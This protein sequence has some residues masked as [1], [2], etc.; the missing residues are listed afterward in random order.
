MDSRMGTIYLCGFNKKLILKFQKVTN[1]NRHLKK[2]GVY[3]SWNETNDNQ[4]KNVLQG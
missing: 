2:I 4:D 1:Y 3:N